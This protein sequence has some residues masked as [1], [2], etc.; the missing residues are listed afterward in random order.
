L[1]AALPHAPAPADQGRSGDFA[2]ELADVHYAYADRIALD[3]L[4]L[5]VPAGASYGLL[6][7]NGSGKSTALALTAGLRR[8][9]SGRV[10]VLGAAPSPSTRR[11]MGVV[12]Q[13]PSLDPLM[14]VA[15]TMRLHA[16]LFGLPAHT[17]AA[18]TD[19]L[20]ERYGLDG[21][22]SDRTSTLSGGL[23][24]RL[25]LAR[26]MLSG[27]S[28][29]LLDE[30]TLGLD[31]D[32]R[33]ALWSHLRDATAGGCTLLVATNDVAEA[34]RS[35]DT[36]ALIDGGRAVCAG[37]P[38]ALKRDLRRQS[39]RID[40]R[41]EAPAAAAA[42]AAWPGVGSLSSAPRVTHASVD[43]GRAFVA[44]VVAEHGADLAGVGIHESTLEDVYVALA[45]KEFL[46]RPDTDQAS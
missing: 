17:A 41:D 44:R 2:V 45:G 25:E 14:T 30:P 11:Q 18:R 13:E 42:M 32:S 8:P 39:V 31:V 33:L 7:P 22:R 4:T 46:R 1:T 23:K 21:R 36:I 27:P 35:C 20:L 24:R 9:D 28:L 3:G 5:A 16:R 12:F 43:D 40:W 38:A 29:L 37:T 26:V 34:E 19:E 10:T 6:G 15:E